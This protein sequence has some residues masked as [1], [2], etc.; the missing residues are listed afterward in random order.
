VT[1]RLRQQLRETD[2]VA[3]IGGDEF[4]IVATN[5]HAAGDAMEIAEKIVATMAEIEQIDGMHCEV[6]ISVG[7]SVFPMDVSSADMLVQHA[8]LAMYKS[9][10]S[11]KGSVNF[12]DARMDA[13]VKA[14]HEL[15]RSMPEDIAAG[16][17][18]LLFQPI[19]NAASRR[20]IGAEALARWRDINNKVIGPSEF[21]PIAE[22]SGSIASLG[23][24]LIEEACGQ[25]HSWSSLD[26]ALVPISLNI[27]AIQ[28][29]D[30]AFATRLIATLERLEVP[31]RLINIEL[32]ES[33]IFRNLEVIQKNLGALKSY[34]IGVHIDDF[35]TGY[36][37]LSLLRDL[38][39]DAVKI[40]RTF[41]RDVGRTVGSELIVQAVVDLS[42]KLGF[43]TIA[44][45]VESEEQAAMLRDIGIDALQGYYFSYPVPGPQLAGWL[46]RTEAHLVA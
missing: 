36:S 38:P 13:S 42:K 1:R 22:E 34:G 6:S 4:A 7:I 29:R 39:L 14:R 19:V 43:A 41:V 37:S 20:L 23:G 18:Y 40:D 21:I 33:T 46:A 28:C 27:S 45:G 16:R 2:F 24:K 10:A 8:D 44:E 32:T 31:P 17:F 35:G 30:P 9:K 15:K 12:F 3:R 26:K 11:R 5:L 25:I